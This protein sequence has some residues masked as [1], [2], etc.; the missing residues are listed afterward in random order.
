MYEEKITQEYKQKD[1]FEF[2][3]SIGR[4]TSEETKVKISQVLTGKKRTK[5]TKERIVKT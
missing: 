5:E 1:Q 3:I 4:K 2:N